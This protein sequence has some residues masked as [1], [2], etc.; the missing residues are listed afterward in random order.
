V[1]L[2]PHSKT[3]KTFVKNVNPTEKISSMQDLSKDNSD[4]SSLV[5]LQNSRD[6]YNFP[7]EW[8]MDHNTK[9][10]I[11]INWVL[12]EK[13]FQQKAKIKYSELTMRCLPH[14]TLKISLFYQKN[15]SSKNSLKTF[16]VC[17]CD[18]LTLRKS[19]L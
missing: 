5:V 19:R 13:Y 10:R 6:E 3:P 4:M 8:K 15:N 12:D 14:G 9:R 2:F 7:A 1:C 18:H 16:C 11:G 17:F